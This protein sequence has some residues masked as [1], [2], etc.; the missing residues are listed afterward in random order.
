MLQV[1]DYEEVAAQ[2]AD[3]LA[4]H[5]SVAF[6]TAGSGSSDS[7]FKL[8]EV[9]H[10]MT[11]DIDDGSATSENLRAEQEYEQGLYDLGDYSPWAINRKAQIASE[12]RAASAARARAG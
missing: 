4:E 12:A 6:E 1:S 8:K 2:L 7:K 10:K 3:R 9:I 5:V 11:A